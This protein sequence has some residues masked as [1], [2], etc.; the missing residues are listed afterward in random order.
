[1]KIQCIVVL[2][3]GFFTCAYSEPVP[4]KYDFDPEEK[5]S[6]MQEV[7][8]LTRELQK[9]TFIS[10]RKKPTIRYISIASRKNSDIA[11]LR[12]WNKKVF[13]VAKKY[14]P[15]EAVEK[16]LQGM[17][18]MVVALDRSGKILRVRIDDSS[19]HQVLDDAAKRF[20]RLAGPFS[21]VPESVMR[22]KDELHIVLRCTFKNR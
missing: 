16:N 17:V 5:N 7:M 4:K 18:L 20:I 1:M 10:R 13:R 11:Y 12:R 22:N 8:R 15:K 3:T 19:G 6:R 21:K 14:Y 2:L 9:I